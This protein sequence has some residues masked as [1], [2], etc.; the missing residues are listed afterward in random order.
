[1]GKLYKEE[2]LLRL[3]TIR[4]GIAEQK[5]QVAETA[6]YKR[7]AHLLESPHV[8]TKKHQGFVYLNVKCFQPKIFFEET[9]NFSVFGCHL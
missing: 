1:M 7:N 8:I 5:S 6:A 2:M 4:V 9:T 3:H